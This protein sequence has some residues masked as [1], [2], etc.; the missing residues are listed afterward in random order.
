MG[1]VVMMMKMMVCCGLALLA[2]TE[3]MLRAMA[4]ATHGRIPTL[5]RW[6]SQPG[7]HPGRS[8]LPR[9]APRVEGIIVNYCTRLRGL[10][11]LSRDEALC[12]MTWH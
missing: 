1:M 2:N 9:P 7:D 12:T 4:T 10:P 11:W 3:V 6:W 5:G 8:S